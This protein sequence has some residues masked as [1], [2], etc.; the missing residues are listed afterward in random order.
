PRGAVLIGKYLAYLA[1]TVGVVLPSVVIVWLLVVPLGGSL[2]ANFIDLAMD[3][4]IL[5][6][7]LAAYGAVFACIGSALKRAV[8][9]GLFLIL[10]WEPAVLAFPGYLKHLTVAYYVQG[11]V[12]HAMPNDSM[13]SLIQGLVRETPTLPQSFVAIGLI[14][15]FCLALGARNVAN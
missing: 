12:P 9:I 2:G 13:L 15:A 14:I 4:M 5:A 7:G 1:C 10:G 6:I 3:L 11:L 8:L